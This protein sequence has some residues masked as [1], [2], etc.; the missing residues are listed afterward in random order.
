MLK[1]K[2][3]SSGIGLGNVVVL[4]KVERNVDNKFY[5]GGSNVESKIYGANKTQSTTYNAYGVYDMNGGAWER[6][7]SYANY[8]DN[9]SSI[10]IITGGYGEEGSFLGKDSIERGISTAYK[11]VY[12]TNITSQ[13]E[14]YN[15]LA[16]K[17][18]VKKGDA[19]YET[20]SS[21]LNSIGSWFEAN[22]SFPDMNGPFF[23]RSGDYS[24][25]YAGVFD[26]GGDQGLADSYGSFRT[27]LA[28]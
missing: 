11:T 20:S 28:F 19:V 2:G 3:V 7:A 15:L 22:A 21:H 10:S 13:L 5:T 26:F 18:T 23:V 6:V 27:A 8:E 17:G 12:K 1:G 16:K 24:Y 4:K 9:I 25:V 14:S